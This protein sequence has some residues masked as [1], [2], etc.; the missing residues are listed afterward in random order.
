VLPTQ[1]SDLSLYAIGNKVAKQFEGD[2]GALVWFEG[3]VKKFD[4]ESD[5]YWIVYSDGDS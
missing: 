5:L 1:T 4:K 2:N 3:I